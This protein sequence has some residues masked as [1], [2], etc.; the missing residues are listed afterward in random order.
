MFSILEVRDSTMKV[1]VI[2]TGTELL[3]G[4]ITNTHLT[5]FAHALFPLGL[6]VV[7]QVTVPDGDAIREA[8]SE[9]MARSEIILIT[10]GLGP[11]TDDLTRDIVA[12]TLGLALHRD[13]AVIKTITERFAARRLV[14]TERNLRQAEVPEGGLVLPNAH[15]TAP[16]IYIR[17]DSP[18]PV[19]IFLLPGPPRELYPMFQEQV[20]PIL[21]GIAPRETPH[22]CRTFHILGLGESN[23]EALVGAQLL[24]IHGLEL[25]YCSRPG[26]VDV[27]CV[28]TAGMLEQAEKIV[29][30]ALGDRIAARDGVKLEE[31]AVATL[32]SRKQTIA[33]AES[34][35]GGLLAHRLTN[36]PGASAVLLAGYVTYSNEAKSMD[37]GVNPFLIETHGAVSTE[38][39]LAMAEGA[40]RRSGADWALSTTGIAG[41]HGGTPLKPL[42]T[43]Y[44][45]LAHRGAPTRVE[46]HQF[47]R[48]RETFKNLAT[49]AALDLLRRALGW[50]G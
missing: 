43:V 22:L 8:L 34:C 9:S 4:S 5:Y 44:I 48:D 11:T 28:G 46:S 37:L 20:V 13:P 24:A 26:E 16:G 17:S 39:A 38:V 27:R 10:G 42:G 30:E 7:R 41:P 1:E 36:V 18:R 45:A 2:N 49:N 35:T 25:G 15:G 23:V 19:H 40:L 6:R 33:T 3:L 12:E 47:S 31:S 50:S 32:S 14:M 21:Q 29:V